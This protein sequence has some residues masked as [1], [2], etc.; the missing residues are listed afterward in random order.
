MKNG[1]LTLRRLNT[2]TFDEALHL[3]NRGFEEY[4]QPMN[5]T[6]DALVQTFG[7]K[8]IQPEHSVVAYIDDKLAG[9]VFLA[10]KRVNG[11]L[12]AWNGGTGV[13]PE[14]R[15]RG[16][17]KA[18]M[19]EADRVLTDLKVERALLEV[20]TKNLNAIAAYERAGFR[21]ADK[22]VGLKNTGAWKNS[23]VPADV[24]KGWS[25]RVGVPKAVSEIPFYQEMRPW[26]G[27]WHSLKEGESLIIQDEQE[28]IAAYAL[29]I[30][31]YGED[32]KLFAIHLFQ[33]E[34]APNRTDRE[35]IF[36]VCLNGVFGPWDVPIERFGVDL[37]ASNPDLIELILGIG[38]EQL[39]EQHLM[40]RE[41]H[42]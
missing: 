37:S 11:K 32:G 20:I 42:H 16:V 2:C 31:K 15:G 40:I 35:L 19:V 13:F 26:G 5:T 4:Y 23:P 33:C 27:Q 3:R 24:P 10:I 34:V 36:R 18:M 22:L 21:I 28:Q 17:A 6:L 38:F 39:Y 8:H 14:Y 25:V 30:R 1:K 41:N 9:F 12:L 7:I 29:F